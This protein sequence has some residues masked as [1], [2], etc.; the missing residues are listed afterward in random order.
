MCSPDHK[1]AKICKDKMCQPQLIR[2][3]C[4]H[5][6]LSSMFHL[7]SDSTGVTAGISE[8]Q[9]S[10]FDQGLLRYICIF[11]SHLCVLL[12]F[13]GGSDSKEPDCNAGSIPGSRRSPGEGNG[14]PLQY[15]SLENSMDRG[16]WQATV[17][18]VTMS[19]TQLG[20]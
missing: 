16:A 20:D 3:A 19:W 14:N 1:A 11:Y 6:D 18:G 10:E 4:C 12:G 15:S 2:F 8:L 17:Y 7:L 13:S 5:S 9:L